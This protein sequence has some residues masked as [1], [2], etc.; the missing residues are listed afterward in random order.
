MWISI[1]LITNL[2]GQVT[3]SLA[4]DFSKITQSTNPLDTAN[5]IG[6]AGGKSGGFLNIA[7]SASGSISEF[8]RPLG[9]HPL[10]RGLAA[11]GMGIIGKIFGGVLPDFILSLTSFIPGAS[12]ILGVIFDKVVSFS[13]YHYC[14]SLGA[15][16]ALV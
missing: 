10:G 14:S 13:Y 16:S 9:E 2:I 8:F 6:G 11:I 5:I 1:Y 7:G 4:S 3:P 12:K 15:Y